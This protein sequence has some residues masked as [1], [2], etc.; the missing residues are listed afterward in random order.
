MVKFERFTC[1]EDKLYLTVTFK[2]SSSDQKFPRDFQS[3]RCAFISQSKPHFQFAMNI[4]FNVVE[5]TIL[6]NCVKID[7]ID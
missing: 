4:E 1:T 5:G 6:G 2:T 3:F 7:N